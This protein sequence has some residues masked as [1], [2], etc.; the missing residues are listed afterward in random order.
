MT[1]MVTKKIWLFCVW[2]IVGS[3]LLAQIGDFG[4]AG[5]PDITASADYQNGLIVFSIDVPVDHHITDLKNNFFSVTLPENEWLKINRTQFPPGETYK[6]ETVFKGVVK[7]LAYV[8]SLKE[9]P[10]SAELTF[11]VSYQVCREFPSEVCFPP[12]SKNVTIKIDSQFGSSS[13]EEEHSEGVRK[14]E[15]ESFSK[16]MQ[17]IITTELNKKSLLLF[18][19]VFIAGFIMSLTPCVYPVIPIIMGFIGTRAKNSKLKSFYLSLLFVL[20]LSLVYSTLGVVAALTGSMIGVSFQNPAVVIVVAGIFIVMGLSLA[21]LFEIPVPSSMSRLMQSG[22]KNDVFG[23]LMIGGIAGIIAAPCVGPVLIALLTWISQTKDAMMGFGITFTFSLGMG[24]LFVVVGTFTGIITSLPKGGKWMERIKQ[25]SAIL[26][27]GAGIFFLFTVFRPGSGTKESGINWIKNLDDGKKIALSEKKMLMLDTYAS[28]CVGC[29]ELDK[30]T[31][32]DSEVQKR[33][34]GFV[35]VKMD[36]TSRNEKNTKLLKD[37]NVFGLPTI[38][39]YDSA[40]REL[41]RFFG[42]KNKK[43]FIKILESLP[44]PKQ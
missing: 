21:G 20:G 24:V 27:I 17:R 38:I 32:S 5:D 23:S 6:D 39:F 29:R 11:K 7:V 25:I 15:N 41:K 37:L 33:L 18:V 13:A 2:L 42:Y 36:F 22:P 43:E 35:L 4:S 19:L 8:E 9:L 3:A 1:N 44:P 12:S 31:F 34:E 30:Y 10:D 40:G 16:W 14:R 28:W 26:L